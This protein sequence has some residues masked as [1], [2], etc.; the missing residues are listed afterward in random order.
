MTSKEKNRNFGTPS[1]N[2]KI[3]DGTGSKNEDNKRPAK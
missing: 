2:S 1:P 3:D